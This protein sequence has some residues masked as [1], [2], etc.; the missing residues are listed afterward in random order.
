VGVEPDKALGAA[1][2]EAIKNLAV[3][4]ANERKRQQLNWLAPLLDF[5]T[6]GAKKISL[7]LLEKYA[8]NYTPGITIVL[9]QG[10]LYFTG[11]SGIKRKLFALAEDYFLLEDISVPPENQARVRFIRNTEGFVTELQLVVADGRAFPRA[12]EVK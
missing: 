7:S 10:Q 2:L 6:D 4:T 8:G 1:H 11:V 9:E 3:K 5:E 12:R